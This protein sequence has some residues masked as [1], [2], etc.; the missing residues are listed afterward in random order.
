VRAHYRN[1]IQDTAGNI[2]PGASV[3]VYTPGTTTPVS[4]TLYADGSSGTAL[5]NPFTSLDGVASFYLA[6]S[7]RVDLGI[8][9]VGGTQIIF[10]DLDVGVPAIAGTG[11]APSGDSTGV[12]DTA[13]IQGLLNLASPGSIVQL[14]PGQFRTNAEITVPPF[15]TLSGPH[16]NRTDNVQLSAT[17]KPVASFSGTACL[18]FKDKEEGGYSTDNNGIR[19]VNLTLDGSATSGTVEGIRATGLVHGVVLDRVAIQ[20][21]SSYG[22]G[23]HT[24]TRL[25]TSVQHPYSWNLW[26][27]MSWQNHDHGYF[28]GNQQTDCTFVNCQA[29]GN[30]GDGFYFVSCQ[31]SQVIGCRSE[32][33]LNGFHLTGS[34]GTTTASGGMLLIGSTDR[35]TQ[36]GVLIDSTGNGSHTV[37]VSMRRD[38]RNSNTG[39]GSFAGLRVNGATTPVIVTGLTC[40]PGVDD[41]GTGVSSPQYGMSITGTPTY[42]SVSGAFLHAA[43]AGVNWDGTG[44]LVTRGVTTRTGSTSSPSA[45]LE[46]ADQPGGGN[47]FGTGADGTATLDGVATV[48]WATLAGS[49]Y[50]M[51]RDAHLTGLTVNNGV[52]LKPAN[53]RIFCQGLVTNSGTITVAGTAATGAT[54][55]P[56][57]GSAVLVGGRAGGAGGTGVSGAGG[58]G[59]NANMGAAAGAGGAGTSGAAGTAGTVTSNVSVAVAQNNLLQLPYGLFAGVAAWAATVLAFGFGAGGGGGGS[60]AS[61]NPGGGGGAGGGILAIFAW[62]LV[63]TATGILTAAGGAGANGTAGNAGGGGGGAGGLVVVYTLAPWTQSGSATAVGGAKGNH[64]GTGSDG[65]IG[66]N[67]LVINVVLN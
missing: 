61:S 18:R 47:L 26:N 54:A 17:I 58:A 43:T 41:D 36:N 7:Q 27:C 53:F 59:T 60:D 28:F 25:D 20:Q 32:F 67:G 3:A 65:V 22:V 39:G 34:W 29:L 63:N 33:N 13:N 24:Y 38:G 6:E 50:T 48:S 62:A 44:T 49:T 21:F 30:V 10:H 12:A 37:M 8:T 57:G 4:V 45:L 9:P 52:T 56:S 55:G 15:V 16:G 42:V 31:N 2:S 51:T 5:T 40:Y 14:Q 35:N 11:L 64:V 66:G 1:V 46:A 19:I 23:C